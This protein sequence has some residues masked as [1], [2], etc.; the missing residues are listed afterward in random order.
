ML[1]GSALV[2]GRAGCAWAAKGAAASRRAARCASDAAALAQKLLVPEAADFSFEPV[3]QPAAH[4]TDVPFRKLE[5]LSEGLSSERLRDGRTLLHIEPWVLSSLA[6]EALTD[7]NHYFRPGHLGQLKAIL[8]DPEASANDKLVARE[9]LK[10]AVVAA[11]RQLPSCQDTGTATVVA[12][13]G[14]L[15]MTDGNDA[16]YFSRGIYD[17]YV[18]GNLRYSQMAPYSLFE[19]KNTRNNLP[20]Q[21]DIMTSAGDSYEMLF[22]AKGGGSANKTKLH[23]KTKAI[24]REDAF[25][26]FINEEIRGVGTAACPPYHL[27]VCVG[28]LSPEM[29]MKTVKLLSCRFYDGLPREGSPAGRAIRDLEWEEKITEVCRNSGIGAQYGGKYFVHDV[30]VARLPRHGGSCPVGISMSCSADRQILARISAD[31]VFLE[32]LERDPDKYLVVDEQSLPAEEHRIDLN[33]NPLEELSKLPVSTRVLMTG[34]MLVMRDIAH[35]RVKDMLEK[36]EPMPQY[37]RDFPLFYAGPSKTPDGMASGSFGP[38]SSVRMDPYVP[39]LQ[40]NG[41]SL[42]MIGKGNRSRSVTRSCKKNGGFYLGTIGGMAAQLSSSCIQHVEVL[43]FHDL[44]MESVFKI[45]VE[46]FP[47]FIVVDD[48]GNDFFASWST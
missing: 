15:V 28:G 18:N 32:E 46:D 3:L 16:E 19:E 34:S 2:S 17:A 29:T 20:A 41:G 45:E 40:K 42:I 38:T 26:E 14:H 39:L 30:R 8:E 36:G 5:S 10:N 7:V 43:D 12:N 44:G 24:L 35:A 9:L 13:R 6:K 1:F 25:M 48:K 33:K 22:L 37:L 27:S 21:I 47:A 11:G 4:K 23:Q 31:G